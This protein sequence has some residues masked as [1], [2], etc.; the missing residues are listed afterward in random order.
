[1]LRSLYD[2]TISLA[3]TRYALLA[4]AV[5]AFIEASVFPIPPDVL[6]IPM[7]LAAPRR[8][9]LIALVATVGSVLGGLLGYAIGAFLF[10]QVGQPILASLGKADDMEAFSIRFNDYGFWSV[11]TAGITPFPF[12][13]ITIM[14]GWTAMPLGTF[15]VTA[16]VARALR[17]FIV[18]ALLWE[19]GAPIR[20]FIEKRLGIVFT[21]FV[22]LLVGSFFLVKY[23]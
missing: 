14:S 21:L 20:D 10:E 15:I 4:L 12:K 3:A 23:L 22:V 7:V 8:A 16:I 9:W 17:F 19:Y 1:M 2:W 5:V 11:L 13:V 6:I 18:A